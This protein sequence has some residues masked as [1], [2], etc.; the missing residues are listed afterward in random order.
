MHETDSIVSFQP[1][2]LCKDTLMADLFV[3]CVSLVLGAIAVGSAAFNWEWSFRMTK[4]QWLESRYGRLSTRVLYAVVG[5]G[6][7]LLGVNLV[8]QGIFGR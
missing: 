1:A 7:A 6:L 5:V 8:I 4:T 2:I 3:G